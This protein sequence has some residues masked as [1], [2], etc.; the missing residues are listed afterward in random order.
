MRHFQQLAAGIDTLPLLL[1]LHRHSAL[2]DQFASRTGH[3]ESPHRDASDII[4]RCE[5]PEDGWPRRE[6]VP[7]PAWYA[8]PQLRPHIFA[9]MA[10]V[11]GLR[12]GRVLI[13]RLPPGTQ[14]YPHADIGTHALHYDTEPYYARYHTLLQNPR[15]CLFHCGDESVYMEPGSCWTFNN[16]L[17][18]CV[19]NDGDA[20]R[21]S[22]IID[23]HSERIGG[24]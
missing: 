4:A 18:H 16:A 19:T 14:I 23:I 2:W 12:L 7:Y 1:A 9:L 24:Q 8:L 3:P 22:L 21:I 20:D 13:T 6:C 5:R 11:E 17:E 15:G 10:R